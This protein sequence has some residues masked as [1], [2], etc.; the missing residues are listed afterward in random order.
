MSDF[1]NY[2]KVRQAIKEEEISQGHALLVP[3]RR[4]TVIMA[5]KKSCQKDLSVR[6][7]EK[8]SPAKKKSLKKKPNKELLLNLKRKN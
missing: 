6:A 1:Y 7:V 2:P 3:Q 8:A 4:R 5:R